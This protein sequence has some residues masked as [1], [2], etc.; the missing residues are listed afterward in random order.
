M[1][2][3]AFGTIQGRDQRVRTGGRARGR[4]EVGLEMFQERM[5]GDS[6]GLG[7]EGDV[8]VQSGRQSSHLVDNMGDV[9]I[10]EGRRLRV[11]SGLGGQFRMCG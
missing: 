8:R 5:V 4:R 2:P 11:G 3:D 10:L 1:S 6:L 9:T 7:K